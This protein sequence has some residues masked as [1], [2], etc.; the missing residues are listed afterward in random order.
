MIVILSVLV[1]LTLVIDCRQTLQI[2]H[3]A[4]LYETN[5]IL[6]RYPTD[7]EILIYFPCCGIGFLVAMHWMGDVTRLVWAL[8]WL[9]V[10]GWVIRKNL[11]LGLH[12]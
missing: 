2:K 3:H 8:A 1:L 4:D 10:Q 7:P 5:P 6:G 12:L 9:A 11:K